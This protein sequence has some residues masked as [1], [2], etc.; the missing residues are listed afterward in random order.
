[1]KLEVLVD[2]PDDVLSASMAPTERH[3]DALAGCFAELGVSRLVWGYYGDGHGGYLAPA[4]YQTAGTDWRHYAAVY[5][6]GRNP[7]AEAVAAG[8]R[9]GQEVYAY[10]KPY[11]TGPA[12]MFPAGSPEAQQW[13]RL[14]QIGGS[15]AWLD[16]F[17][18]K[19]PH[20]RLEHRDGPAA[21]PGSVPI[22]G[23][24]LIKKNDEPTRVR[25]EHLQIWTS[26][27]NYRYRLA[28]VDFTLRES[29]APAAEDTLDLDGA[30]VAR[31]G[32]PVRVL[33][34]AGLHLTDPF[35]LVTTD[36]AD[37]PG[38][39][40]NLGAQ[41]LRAY[42]A[43]GRPV[44]GVFAS[45]MG[46]WDAARVDFRNWGLMFDFGWQDCPVR[47]D[48]PNA[49]GKQG[50][51]AFARSRNRHLPG[52]LCE[53][54]P[55]VRRFWLDGLAEM[56]AAGVDG[57]EIRIENHST[58]TDYPEEYGFNPAVRARCEQSGLSVPEARGEAYTE[59]LRAAG[60]LLRAR[61]KKL[62]IN[63][64]VDWFRA[65][66]PRRRRLAYPANIAFQWQRWIEEGLLD[67]ATLRSYH[68]RD[69]V[70]NDPVAAEMLDRCR[71]RRIP[72]AFNHHV[73]NEDRWF[74]DEF[75]RVRDSGRFASCI[76]YETDSFAEFAGD[77]ACAIKLGIIRDI[78]RTARE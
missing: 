55:Q 70:L 75:R 63:L 3:L 11:E 39:F 35:I 21:T 18:V 41:I 51:I 17:V 4:G 13:G 64:N 58:H 62:R 59:F 45:G 10:F 15:L 23:L 5:G 71:A 57:V 7:L 65:D 16:P 8:H 28:A 1:M 74:L 60:D 25:K 54:E 69:K 72:V 30:I 14:D 49:S 2:F 47:L 67:E 37:G 52:A 56:L 44:R 42:D 66:P 34:L 48:A 61:G 26:P 50:F 6:G 27:D 73:F 31:K 46:I 24:R 9:H 33:E 19:H 12:L 32:S 53:T 40:E 38:D 68:L 78:A 29:M 36:F 22:G 20:L 77:A 76:L 43:E